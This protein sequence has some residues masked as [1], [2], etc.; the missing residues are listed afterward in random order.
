M[1]HVHM[2]DSIPRK[3]LHSNATSVVHA[4]SVEQCQCPPGYDGLSCEYCSAGYY[5]ID[6]G[7]HGGYCVQCQ[8]NG[9]ATDCDVNTG[10]CFVSF[11]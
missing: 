4:L 7:P 5:R 8:C 9:H 3:Y 2:D 10:K 1:L 6:S 11:T